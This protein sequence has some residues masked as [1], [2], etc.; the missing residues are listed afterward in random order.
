MFWY[1]NAGSVVYGDSADLLPV[2]HVLHRHVVPL[3]HSPEVLDGKIIHVELQQRDHLDELGEGSLVVRK[4]RSRNRLVWVFRF[5][6]NR[7]RNHVHDSVNVL[8]CPSL[9]NTTTHGSN[10]TRGG[11]YK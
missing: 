10:Q 7:L 1:S 6:F 4:F 5:E 3:Q 9:Q 8:H 11:Q 2:A